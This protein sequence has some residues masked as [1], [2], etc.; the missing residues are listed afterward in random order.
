MH[1]TT[2]MHV[3]TIAK[4]AAKDIRMHGHYWT[5]PHDYF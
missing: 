1:A 5:P 3:G 2:K 4:H